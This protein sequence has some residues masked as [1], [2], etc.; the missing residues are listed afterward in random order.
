MGASAEAGA[1]RFIT[2]QPNLVQ[3]SGF[4]HAELAFTQDGAPS[5]EIGAAYGAPIINDELGF[6]VSAWMREDGGYINRVNPIDDQLV[7][8]DAN[9]D[10]KAVM[11]AA[12]TLKVADVKITPSVFYQMTDVNNNAAFYDYF[13]DPSQGEFATG[14][15]IPDTSSEH[16]IVPSVKVRSTAVIRR[17]SL[18]MTTSYVPGADSTRHR[19]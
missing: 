5:Y 8:T 15:L 14:K 10:R 18:S 12:L 16:L 3:A 13:S 7:S 4:S 2:N 11:R 1:V 6:R 17:I 19:T 9:S